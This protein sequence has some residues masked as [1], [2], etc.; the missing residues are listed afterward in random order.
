LKEIGE[1]RKCR[2]ARILKGQRHL[3]KIGE[4]ILSRVAT[5]ANRTEKQLL[6]QLRHHVKRNNRHDPANLEGKRTPEK[7]TA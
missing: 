5:G 2:R 1:C 4:K 7:A 3:K 6:R